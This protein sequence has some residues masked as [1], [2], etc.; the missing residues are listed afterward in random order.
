MAKVVI[1]GT[2]HKYQTDN[3]EAD[4]D[5]IEQFRQLLIML[6]SKHK[7]K[8]IAEEMNLEGLK[9]RGVP[10]SIACRVAAELKLSH[11]FSD[12][13]WECRKELGI[14][15]EIDIR[16]SGWPNVLSEERVQAEIRKSHDIRERYWLDQLMSINLAPILFVCG[17]DHSEPFAKLLR[18]SNF[19][20]EVALPDWEPNS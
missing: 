19:E 11:Q 18:E 9:E 12:P 1:I 5:S 2:S 16:I 14:L 20:V 3:G 17:A 7:A 13:S 8:A 6:C 4:A 10:E 15:Q